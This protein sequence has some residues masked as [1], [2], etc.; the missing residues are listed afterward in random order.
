MLSFD[1]EFHVHLVVVFSARALGA[2]FRP[3]VVLPWFPPSRRWVGP[4]GSLLRPSPLRFRVIF[5]LHQE[6]VGAWSTVVLNAPG[7]PRG[8]V[9]PVV[10]LVRS[11]PV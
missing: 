10:H 9:V 1:C 3:G 6:N 8:V 2:G 7:P 11:D 4:G 5:V